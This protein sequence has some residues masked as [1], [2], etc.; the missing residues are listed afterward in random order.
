M[1]LCGV[2]VEGSGGLPLD[3]GAKITAVRKY[4]RKL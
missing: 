1:K 4:L 2:E 3:M